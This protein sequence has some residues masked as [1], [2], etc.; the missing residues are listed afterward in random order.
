MRKRGLGYEKKETRRKG[1]EG[2]ELL[3]YDKVIKEER[4]K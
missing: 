2:R 3:G 4:K 1:N